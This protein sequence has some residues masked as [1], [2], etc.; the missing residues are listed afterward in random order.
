MA[1]VILKNVS[2]IYS[3]GIRAVNNINLEVKNKEF[4][5]LVGPSGCGKSTILR[6]IAG[7][8]EI[9]K[10]EVYIEEKMVNNISPKDRNIAMVFQNYA[11]YPHMTVFQNLAFGLR[12]HKHSSKVIKK[13]VSQ[14]AEI[15]GIDNLLGRKPRALSGGQRQRVALGRAIV[16]QPA[17]FLFDEPLSNLDAK[18]RVQMRAEIKKLH[19]RLK[20]TMIY[21]THDQLEAMTMGERIAVVKQGTIQQLSSPSVLY[22]KPV[23]KFAAGFIGSP[24]MNFF[25]GKINSQEKNL[26]FQEDN[27]QIKISP[28]H[29]NKLN[30]MA[31]KEIILGIRPEDIHL[32]SSSL[33]KEENIV[34]SKLEVIEPMG[35]DTFLNFKINSKT[36]VVRVKS[37]HS[38]LEKL[39]VGENKDLI[40]NSERCYYFNP[41]AE[42]T[43]V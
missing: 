31:E 27:F 35:A 28:Q 11:L 33:V 23:N 20:T 7:L 17:V 43:I 10:G 19:Q 40:F 16:R 30:S 36:F 25:K 37:S 1:K 13:R 8:E 29:I 15:L 38:T 2:K 41:Q 12:L 4:L 26:Y 34:R 6:M 39:R 3:N 18:F 32:S 42:E 14:A 9:S 22:Y 24:P 21:V 5:V